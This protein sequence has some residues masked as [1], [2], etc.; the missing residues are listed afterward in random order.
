MK[1]VFWDKPRTKQELQAST[2][3]YML[4]AA[5]AAPSA[6]SADLAKAHNT[7][8]REASM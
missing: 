1:A 7:V 6:S 2:L 3:M 8:V 5:S 4:M